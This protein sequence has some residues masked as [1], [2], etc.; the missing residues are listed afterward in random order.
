MCQLSK[1][2]RYLYDDFLSR[3]GTKSTLKKGNY[4]TIVNVLMQLRK[5][6]N[7]PNLFAEPEV[8]SPFVITNPLTYTAPACVVQAFEDDA[9]TGIL[10]STRANRGTINLAFLNLCL[11]HHELNSDLTPSGYAL[12]S[13]NHP[14]K[15][16]H[17]FRQRDICLFF[18][19][20]I[21]YSTC[22]TLLDYSLLCVN[23]IE[24]YTTEILLPKLDSKLSICRLQSEQNKT[25]PKSGMNF[26][27]CKL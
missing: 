1:R 14:S 16:R 24:G 26:P 12:L 9:Y 27:I 4:I 7:H 17:R 13:L 23:L 2:Q 15:W 10:D 18:S 21:Q 8:Q 22:I 6:C 3:S 19:Q 5:V 20:V 11:L 25:T